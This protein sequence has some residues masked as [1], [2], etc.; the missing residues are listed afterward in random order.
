MAAL[1]TSSLLQHLK[2]ADG[3]HVY[4]SN[5][6][7]DRADCVNTLTTSFYIMVSRAGHTKLTNAKC[8]KMKQMLVSR[9]HS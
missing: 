7:Q 8:E 5:N 9:P 2:R 6:A 3:G 4:F 1:E